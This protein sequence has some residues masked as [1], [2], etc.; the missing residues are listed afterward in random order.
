MTCPGPHS[1]HVLQVGGFGRSSWDMP[2]PPWLTSLPL[3]SPPPPSPKSTE[4][5]HFPFL[6]S[7]PVR[8]RKE[9]VFP[10]TPGWSCPASSLLYAVVGNLFPRKLWEMQVQGPG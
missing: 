10:Y 4:E 5:N 1:T 7:L 8:G 2:A 3:V 6:T 9:E